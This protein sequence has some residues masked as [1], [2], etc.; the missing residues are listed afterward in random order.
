MNKHSVLIVDDVAENIDILLGLLKG[1]YRI[2]AATDGSKALQIARSRE[3]PDIILL[4]IMMPGMSGYDVCRK[5]KTLN[6]TRDIPVIF[7][8]AISELDSLVKGFEAGGVDYIVKPFK[9]LELTTRLGTQLKLKEATDIIKNQNAVLESAVRRKT[10]RLR[11]KNELLERTLTEKETLLKE[12]RNMERALRRSLDMLNGLYERIQGI[13]EEERR[14]ISTDIHDRLGQLLTAIKLNLF[15]LR[16]RPGAEANGPADR[17]DATIRMTDDALLAVQTVCKQLRPDILDNLGFSEAVRSYCRTM[18]E[19][20][21]VVFTLAV[22]GMPGALGKKK[23]LVLYRV[24]QEACTNTVRHAS[25]KKCEIEIKAASGALRLRISDD[26]IGIGKDKID[27][28]E[29]LGVFGMKKR[30]DDIE[31][32]FLIEGTPGKGTT[33]SIIVPLRGESGD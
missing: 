19:S 17:I 18:Q 12:V 10:E 9:P 6:S 8:T 25:A 29:S 13:Q 2:M 4:D 32:D 11:Q 22:E 1:T 3:P 20:S 14:K 21:G 15:R 23:E 7:L 27:D 5:L 24:I 16:E 31:G 30:I 33:I 28:A 26:G